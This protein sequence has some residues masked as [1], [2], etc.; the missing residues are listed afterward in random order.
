MNATYIRH[1]A[2]RSLN[3]RQAET[4]DKLPLTRAV[5]ALAE[6][7]G[8]T[9]KLAREALKAVGP[10][11]WHHV[12]KFANATDYYSLAGAEDW[13]RLKPLRDRLP[14]D[15]EDRYSVGMEARDLEERFA[16]RRRNEEE[17]AA[18]LQ[19]DR[20]DLRTI[21]YDTYGEEYTDG[22]EFDE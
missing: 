18:E 15:F 11:E 22:D 19:C 12:G 10:C 7:T 17:I 4:E 3:A 8:A 1:G 5:S 14:A 6:R 16:A 2:G 13:L 20:H 9:K 21:Y